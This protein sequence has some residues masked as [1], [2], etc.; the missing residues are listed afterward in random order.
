MLSDDDEWLTVSSA[1]SVYSLA[2]IDQ[3]LSDMGDDDDIDDQCAVREPS[4]QIQSTDI[5]WEDEDDEWLYLGLDIP[6]Y[7][8]DL[9]D[10]C[11]RMIAC[12]V[13]QET[14]DDLTGGVHEA[15]QGCVRAGRLCVT[16][17]CRMQRVVT[18]ESVENRRKA[19]LSWGCNS[20]K[21]QTHS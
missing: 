4:V 12:T 16:H 18:I 5:V 10:L 7:T 15:D 13:S 1:M 8:V 20:K 19:G 17:K 9:D 2:E 6:V 3:Y 11:A 21:A 14:K